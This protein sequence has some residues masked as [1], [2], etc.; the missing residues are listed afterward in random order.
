M[1]RRGA[2]ASGTGTRRIGWLGTCL[3]LPRSLVSRA[4]FC[5]MRSGQGRPDGLEIRC[6]L[7]CLGRAC[8]TPYSSFNGL[9]QRKNARRRILHNGAINDMLSFYD[10]RLSVSLSCYPIA[11]LLFALIIS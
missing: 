4:C 8:S 5:V 9:F 1:A 11:V 6:T 7:G 3:W 2:R 10:R